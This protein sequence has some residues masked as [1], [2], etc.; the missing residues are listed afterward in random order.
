MDTETP[1]ARAL[2]WSERALVREPLASP[3]MA[4]WRPE[5]THVA[6]GLSQ[7]AEGETTLRE[8]VGAGLVR[9]QSG[10]G[11]VL[12]YPGV[13]CWEAMARSDY[14]K[15]DQGDDGIR[16]SYRALVKPVIAGLE[17]IGVRAFVAGVSDLS[18]EL[19]PDMPPRKIAGTAQLRRRDRILVHGSLLVEADISLL[20]DYLSPPSVK[21]EYRGDRAHIDF[22][23]A[24]RELTPAHPEP[25]ALVAAV[26]GL[27]SETAAAGGWDVVAPPRRLDADGERLEKGKYLNPEWNWRRDRGMG[28]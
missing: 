7:S 4:L 18:V 19:S 10:G 26:A 23:V 25:G 17:R 8:G 6:I 13:L 22:C 24:V 3:L 2:A 28:A 14:V 12:L 16:A 27:V 21:P 20:A 9:R 15:R 11:A 1:P 5:G